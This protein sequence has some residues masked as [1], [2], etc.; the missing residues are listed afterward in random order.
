MFKYET[1]ESI[2]NSLILQD[3]LRYKVDQ[4]ANHIIL[5]LNKDNQI[6]K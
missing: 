2:K 6:V 1:F 4:L 5:G 3:I